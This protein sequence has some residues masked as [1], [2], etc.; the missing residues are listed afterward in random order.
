MGGAGKGGLSVGENGKKSAPFN[1]GSACAHV[2]LAMTV[3]H[4]PTISAPG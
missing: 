3:A 2:V 1:Q 4:Q